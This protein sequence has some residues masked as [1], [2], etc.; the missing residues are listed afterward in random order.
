MKYNFDEC[1]EVFN[2]KKNREMIE[3]ICTLIK[4]IKEKKTNT[5]KTK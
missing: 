4:I 1:L 3:N 2:N 5:L